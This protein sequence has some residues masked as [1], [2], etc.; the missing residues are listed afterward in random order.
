MGVT[1]GKEDIGGDE[2]CT[3]GGML[4][5]WSMNLRHSSE[6]KVGNGA[7]DSEGSYLRG[8]ISVILLLPSQCY[9]CPH[10]TAA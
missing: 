10:E 3:I 7:G 8:Q 4:G 1:N 5:F 2:S 9:C 6:N